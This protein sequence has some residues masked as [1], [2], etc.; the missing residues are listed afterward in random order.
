MHSSC[1]CQ[2][3]PGVFVKLFLR[4]EGGKK[5]EERKE[6]GKKE[7]KRGELRH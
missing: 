6:K 1:V 2:S 4:E 5:R 7:R 3:R